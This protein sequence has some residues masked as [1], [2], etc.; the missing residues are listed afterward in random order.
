MR[1]AI[2]NAQWPMIW[3]TPY[4]MT[5]ALLLGGDDPTRLLLPIVPRADRPRPTFLPPQDDPVLAGFGTLSEG[6][7][8][9][10]G[11]ISRIERD[12]QHRTTKV[13]ATNAGGSQYP[14]G[15][16]RNTESIT[17]EAADD[18]PETTSVTGEYG[19]IVKLPDRTLTWEARLTFTSDRDNFY[20]TYVRR[21]LK[22]GA[23]VREKT[24]TDTIPRDFQ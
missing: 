19:T 20:Y 3:P 6:T 1:L 9:G 12:P 22:D 15:T 10:Y 13:V 23:L 14:W 24:W 2:G 8:S 18:H 5:T 17:H 16:E 4:P 11:E 7:P 21:L